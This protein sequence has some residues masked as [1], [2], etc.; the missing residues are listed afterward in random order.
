M[1]SVIPNISFADIVSPIVTLLAAFSGAWF[2][3]KLHDNKEQRAIDNANLASLNKAIFTLGQQ[4]NTLW[5]YYKQCILPHKDT[6]APWI[7][8]PA[9]LKTTIPKIYIDMPSLI[10]LVRDGHGGLIQEILIGEE[11]FQSIQ[12]SIHSRS[13][14]HDGKL[15]DHL[16]KLGFRDG[17]NEMDATGFENLLVE[18][19]PKLV[20]EMQNITTYIVGETKTTILMYDTLIKKLNKVSKGLYPEERVLNY[21]VEKKDEELYAELFK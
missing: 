4:L 10:F 6:H 16:E 8:I 9:T 20:G 17:S 3:F 14:V 2:A 18:L 13:I 11:N 19:G 1:L 15:Q 12:D 7:S 5:V 21:K